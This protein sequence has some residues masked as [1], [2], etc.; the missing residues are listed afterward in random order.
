MQERTSISVQTGT[1][2]GEPVVAIIPD[3]DINAM[4][5]MGLPELIEQVDD[6]AEALSEADYD[7]YAVTVKSLK[8][9]LEASKLLAGAA[10]LADELH[11]SGQTAEALL[12]DTVVAV[13]KSEMGD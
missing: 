3:G 12:I 4:N 13:L 6:L 11:T 2:N 7:S 9:L 1:A 10:Q 8:Y 5:V